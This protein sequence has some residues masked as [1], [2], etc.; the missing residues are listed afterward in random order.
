MTE[1][2]D[3]S[4]KDLEIYNLSLD[5]IVNSS[6]YKLLIKNNYKLINWVNADLVFVNNKI[7]F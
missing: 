3:T 4:I 2:T 5:K 6:L 7:N 1:I